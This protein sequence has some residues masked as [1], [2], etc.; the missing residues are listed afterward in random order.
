M[1]LALTLGALLLA[2]ALAAAAPSAPAFTVT[3]LD[4]SGHFDSRA[5][6]GKHVLVVRFQASWCKVCNE[7]AE[8]I[9]RSTRST[10]RAGSR[11]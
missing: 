7:E 1:R 8:M 11:W 6:I 10:A 9:E 4:G 5:H 2:P 3:L